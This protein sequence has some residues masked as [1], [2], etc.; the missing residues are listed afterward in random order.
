MFRNSEGDPDRLSILV[1]VIGILG[2]IVGSIATYWGN[3]ELQETEG[4]KA[5]ADA[6]R[7]AK[8]TARVQQG[9]LAAGDDALTRSLEDCRYRLYRV[10]TQLPLEDQRR[11]AAVLTAAEWTTVANGT[12]GLRLQAERGNEKHRFGMADVIQIRQRLKELRAAQVALV[13]T[14]GTQ[15]RFDPTEDIGR[16]CR[17]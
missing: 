13:R 17:P 8:G 14:A 2:V 1:A 9:M 16:R 11:L 4:E 10:P 3:K 5:R 15:P 12:D 6:A 7:V